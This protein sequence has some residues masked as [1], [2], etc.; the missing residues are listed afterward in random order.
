VL[1]T[2]D[3]VSDEAALRTVIRSPAHYVGMIGSRAKC[4]TIIEHLRADGITD[5]HLSRVHAPIGLDLGGREPAEIALAILAEV[6]MARH[7]GS[8][9]PRS[10]SD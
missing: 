10:R 4:E 2:T 5:A 8:G 7:G 3:H 6:E 1:I 9:L